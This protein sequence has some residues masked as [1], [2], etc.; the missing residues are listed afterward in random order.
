MSLTLEQTQALFRLG[1]FAEIV[2]QPASSPDSLRSSTSDFRLLVAHS[3]FHVGD[4][5]RVA[6]IVTRENRH[7]SSL[8]TRAHC[9]LIL[10]L[11]ERRVGRLS[12]C[13]THFKAALHLSREA[14]DKVLAAWAALHRFRTLAETQP[15]DA[16]LAVMR[17]VRRDVT[18]AANPHVTTY[19]HDSIALMEASM[20]RPDEARRHLRICETLLER[21]SNAWLEQLVSVNRSLR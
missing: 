1:R 13:Q 21:Y 3:L 11:L 18:N 2:S 19:L 16:L 10:G 7:E 15:N 8:R 17:E 9:E 6:E 14:N 5:R 12:E 4:A 20:G